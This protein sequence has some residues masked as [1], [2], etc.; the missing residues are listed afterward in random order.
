MARKTGCPL[1]HTKRGVASHSRSLSS[2]P[3]IMSSNIDMKII[4]PWNSDG[5]P[6]LDMNSWTL[7]QSCNVGESCE[8]IPPRIP[9]DHHQL[10]SNVLYSDESVNH[11]NC[12]SQTVFDIV[13]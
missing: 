2:D 9:L 13:F 11:S 1:S 12:R 4:R 7:L 5:S 3:H 10:V 8:K 6:I